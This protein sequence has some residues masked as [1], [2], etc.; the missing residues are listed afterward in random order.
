MSLKSIKAREITF[1]RVFPAYHPKK[2][3]NTFFV[4]SILNGLL[5]DYTSSNYYVWLL[6]NNPEIDHLFL[7]NFF[8]SLEVHLPKRLTGKYHTIRNHKKPIIVGDFISPK[9]WAGKPYNKTKEGYWKIKFAPD[10]EIK[11][12]WDFHVDLNGVYSINGHY[13]YNENYLAKNDGFVS[14]R[15]D[16]F[17][18][19]MANYNK[20]KEFK[21][22]IICWNELITY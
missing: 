5:I 21:G 9:V 2:G 6:E 3:E 4:E 1:S 7:H 19:L 13:F 17:P 15:E 18:W 11:K 14:D 16:L 10:I 8:T 22:N 20:P 12:T